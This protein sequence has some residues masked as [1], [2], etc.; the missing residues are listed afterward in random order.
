MNIT[1]VLYAGVGGQGVLLASEITAR[2]A[3]AAGFEVKTNEVHGMAQRGGSV[4]AQ[5]RWGREVASPLVPKGEARA[6][7][8]LEL[9]EAL[10]YADYVAPGAL[11]VVS[12]QRII[13]TTVSTGQA[14]YPEDAADRLRRVFP[15]LRILAAIGEAEALGNPRAA[16]LIVVGAL[17]TG[18]DL[19]VE[20]WRTAISQIVKPAQLDLN[21]KAFE[22]GRALA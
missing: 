15:N 16:N 1:S 12:D 11:V 19:S 14:R 21:L 22:R 20:H 17:S 9:V 2:A 4:V 6:L 10:R 18:L 8:A 5:V 13:P 3:L 7:G